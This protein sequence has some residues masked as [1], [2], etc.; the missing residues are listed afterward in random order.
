[1]HIFAREGGPLLQSLTIHTSCSQPLNI[2]DQFGSMVLTGFTSDDGSVGS[3]PVGCSSSNVDGVLRVYS[4]NA[5]VRIV[6][7]D[8]AN[9]TS[10]REFQVSCPPIPPTPVNVCDAG[11]KPRSLTMQYV[12]TDCSATSNTQGGRAT[13]SG[14]PADADP[15]YVRVTDRSSP[16]DAGARIYFEGSVML[17]DSFTASSMAANQLNFPA[18]TYF[19]IFAHRGGP[20][21]QTLCVHTSCSQPLFTTDQF[22]S[23]ILIGYNQ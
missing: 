1:V 8:S 15:V 21:L 9:N 22:G 23:L 11:N 14:D 17:E 3:L 10:T 18:N 16:T 13:C 12:G 20:L 6:A 19:H 7:V 5:I 2:G 4:N